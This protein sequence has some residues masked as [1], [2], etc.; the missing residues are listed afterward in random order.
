MKL[1]KI[2]SRFLKLHPKEIDLSLDRII[3]LCKKL[4]DLNYNVSVVD[5]LSTGIKD[6]I[7][8]GCEFFKLDLSLSESFDKLPKN[9]DAV[10]HLASQVSSEDS[11][12]NPINDLRRNAFSTLQLLQWIRKVNIKKIIYTSTMGVYKD[13][14]NKA[15]SESML[16]SPKSFYGIGKMCSEEYIRLFFEESL[17]YPE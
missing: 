2:L 9:F 3:N 14:Q 8:F 15:L 7:P 6:N 11:C 12:D 17:Q 5:D 4:K 13:N 1:Q 10:F 16:L